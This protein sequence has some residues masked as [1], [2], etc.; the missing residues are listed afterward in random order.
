[1]TFLDP[2]IVGGARKVCRFG[3]QER[4]GKYSNC[5]WSSSILKCCRDLTE[6]GSGELE[7]REEADRGLFCD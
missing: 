5:L 7:L 6:A 1:M 2:F 3:K 4:D